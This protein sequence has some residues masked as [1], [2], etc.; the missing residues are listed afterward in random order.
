MRN[1]LSTLNME[2]KSQRKEERSNN[3]HNNHNFTSAAW[4]KS[5]SR[6]M[7]TGTNSGTTGAGRCCARDFSCMLVIVF[8]RRRTA[9]LNWPSADSRGMSNRA[10]TS[11]M[12]FICRPSPTKRPCQN[13]STC[14]SFICFLGKPWDVLCLLIQEGLKRNFT[15]PRCSA[16]AGY[17]RMCVFYYF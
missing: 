2:K 9:R 8:R 11:S 5:W 13:W 10:T 1:L 7:S 4:F 15:L 12:V 17:L 16:W 6:L 3:N 14:R